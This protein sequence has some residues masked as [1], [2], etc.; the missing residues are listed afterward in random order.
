MKPVTG[1]RLCRLLESRGWRLERTNGSHRIYTKKGT[2]A[3]ISVPVHGNRVLKRGLQNC[4]QRFRRPAAPVE[5][6]LNA[7]G[8]YPSSRGPAWNGAQTVTVNSA[9]RFGYGSGANGQQRRLGP[10]G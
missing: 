3:R 4:S 5:T 6:R 9:K 7:G 1:K 8:G 2:V 10:S